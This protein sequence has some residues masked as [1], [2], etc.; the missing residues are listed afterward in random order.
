MLKD[1]FASVSDIYIFIKIK[2]VRI[3]P[4][5]LDGIQYPQQESN[6]HLKFRKL[7]FYPLNY[8]GIRDTNLRILY[9]WAKYI[10]MPTYI[11]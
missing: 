9:E 4:Y 10:N 1:I 8:E 11:G 2:A 3:L 6:L 5:S 7:S